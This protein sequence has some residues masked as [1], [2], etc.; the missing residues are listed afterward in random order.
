MQTAVCC[1]HYN[2][3]LFTEFVLSQHPAHPQVKNRF[4]FFAD[5][6]KYTQAEFQK[7]TGCDNIFIIL[8]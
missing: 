1:I 7:G 5:R 4:Y 8:L 6:A 2:I 3:F